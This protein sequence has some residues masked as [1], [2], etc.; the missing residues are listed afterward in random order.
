M[1]KMSVFDKVAPD[2]TDAG[3]NKF[4]VRELAI[5]GVNISCLVLTLFLPHFMTLA[6]ISWTEIE[7]DL[8]YQKWRRWVSAVLSWCCL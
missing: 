2:A 1:I 6:S 3:Y 7:F 5:L 4:M 8:V